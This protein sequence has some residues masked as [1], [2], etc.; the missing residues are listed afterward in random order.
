MNKF[1][2]YLRGAVNAWDF[3]IDVPL[4][5]PVRTR[6]GKKVDAS[7][8]LAGFPL[9]G[10]VAGV[11]LALVALFCTAVFR[12]VAGCTIFAILAV[13]FLDL[14]DSGRGVA[15]LTGW[16]LMRRNGIS[17]PEALPQLKGDWDRLNHPL[18]SV[19]VSLL[20]L[21]KAAL[22]FSLAFYGGKFWIY[23]IL[24]G[25]FTVQ[26][27][28]A[29]EPERGSGVPLLPV[30]PENRRYAWWAFGILSFFAFLYFP[31]GVVAAVCV[32]YFTATGLAGYFERNFGG[33]SSD[34]ITLAGA[35]TELLLLLVGVLSISM[36]HP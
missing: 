5:E 28:L 11:V 17:F 3:L 25:A 9:V 14:K 26:G 27:L 20:E 4:P 12:P 19:F 2:K 15:L 24:V 13:A 8:I 23:M 31:F 18:A 36:F 10:A 6:F 21:G 22:L 29:M 7:T 1:E 33:V 32:V 30:P 35:L 34:F 16:F